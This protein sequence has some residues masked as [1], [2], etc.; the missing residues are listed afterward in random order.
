MAAKA[1]EGRRVALAVELFFGLADV[2]AR[3]PAAHAPA[4]RRIIA[5]TAKSKAELFR[6]IDPTPAL[7]E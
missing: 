4:L 7:V 5:R 6:M 2:A 1:A 3:R